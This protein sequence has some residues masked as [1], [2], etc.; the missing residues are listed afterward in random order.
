MKA[1]KLY[2]LQELVNTGSGMLCLIFDQVEFS[3]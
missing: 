1:F 3:P 2:S